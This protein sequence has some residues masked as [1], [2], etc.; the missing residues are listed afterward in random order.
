MKLLFRVD[1]SEQ[2]GSGHLMR[3]LTLADAAVEGGGECLFIVRA[4]ADIHLQRLAKSMHRFSVLQH[5]SVTKEH[6]AEADLPHS[7]WLPVSRTTD[8]VQTARHVIEFSPDWVIVDH[9]A[10]DAVW[11]SV[12]RQYCNQLLVIDDV[13]DRTYDCTAILDQNFGVVNSDY[14]SRIIGDADFLL[15]PNFALIRPEFSNVRIQ[16]SPRQQNKVNRVLLNFG[17][18][19]E[20][21]F[22]C[23]ALIELESSKFARYCEFVTVVGAAFPHKKELLK[24]K[25]VSELAIEV[26][27]DVEHMAELMST[28][29][30]CIGATGSTVWERCCV[31]LPTIA[32]AIADNQV[33]LLAQLADTG[34]VLSTDLSKLSRD[35]DSLFSTSNNLVSS[36]SL[37]ASD[38]CDGHGAYRV[39]DY[40]QK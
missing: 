28:V 13:A 31:G 19:D 25:S 14:D 22:T 32:L 34:A 18:V 30:L 27:V 35:F 5:V 15:G 16:S 26:L 40:L 38:L 2:I 33:K 3:C 21:N 17:G 24:L 7:A 8:A 6:H 23:S 37:A 10:L 11:H 20:K 39:L 12:I 36:M 4:A 29:D 9:Y 1:A